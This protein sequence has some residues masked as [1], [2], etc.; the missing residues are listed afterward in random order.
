M[1]DALGLLDRT[2]HGLRDRTTGKVSMMVSP[3]HPLVAAE[4]VRWVSDGCRMGVAPSGGGHDP[5]G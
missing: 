2:I 3:S 4:G 5:A 1:P